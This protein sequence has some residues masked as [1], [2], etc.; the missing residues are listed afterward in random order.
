MF[1][2]ESKFELFWGKRRV[3]VRRQGGE[4]MTRHC[5]VPTVKHGGGSIMV[6]GCFGGGK[7]GD[8]VKIEGIMKKEHYHKILTRHAVPC[9]KR[10][11]G[12]GFVFQQDNDPKHASN[13]CKGYL[14]RKQQQ[15]ELEIM[16]WPPQSP[17]LNPIEL[18]WDELDRKVRLMRPKNKTELWEYLKKAWYSIPKSTLDKLIERMPKVCAAVLKARGGYFEES[19]LVKKSRK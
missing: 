17:D 8:L 4:R 10:L 13:L 11:V 14:V 1:S 12:R 18:L 19:S 2:D 5:V 7:V 15:K 3:Y 9:G 6:W 16:D